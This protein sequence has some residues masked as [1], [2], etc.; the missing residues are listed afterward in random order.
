MLLEIE[1]SNLLAI[2]TMACE[3]EIAYNLLSDNN[4]KTLLSELSLYPHSS[5]RNHYRSNRDYQQM[6]SKF[7]EIFLIVFKFNKSH[8]VLHLRSD[9]TIGN[10]FV[11][12]NDRPL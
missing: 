6:Y 4:A 11:T 9:A 1:D 12:D 5:D 7:I 3:T 10:R 2:N 8:I